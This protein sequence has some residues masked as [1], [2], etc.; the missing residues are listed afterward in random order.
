VVS[1]SEALLTKLG[2]RG[3]V[4]LVWSD[5]ELS[6]RELIVE[7]DRWSERLGAAGLRAGSVLGLRGD[8]SPATCAVTLA[9]LQLRLVLVP[10]TRSAESEGLASLGRVEVL[11]DVAPDDTFSIGPRRRVEANDVLD[12][13]RE[14]GR[15]GLIV[16]SSGST[17]QPKAILHDM[18][19]VL[20]KFEHRRRGYRTLQFLLMDHFGGINTLLSVLSYGGV[21]VAPQDRTPGPVARLI[22]RRGIEL[23]PVTPTFLNLFLASGVATRHDLASVEV[24]TYGTEVMPEATLERLHRAFPSARLQQTYGLSE[25]GVLRSRSKDSDSLWMKVGGEGFETRIEDGTLRVRSDYAMVGYLNAPSPIDD[26]GWMDTGDAVVQEGDW[27]RILGRSSDIINVGGQK[28]FPA[29]VEDTLLEAPRV[30]DAVVR[31]ESHPLMGHVVVAHVSLAEPEDDQVLRERLRAFCRQRLA[32]FK[33]PVRF[34]SDLSPR[35]TERFKK[36]R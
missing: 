11:V 6:G 33:V 16:F 9:A 28:V 22:E 7:S 25:I 21:V 1:R 32:P 4:T 20:A 35:H 36:A 29:E 30:L 8:Y 23:L 5:R 27:L 2:E 3:A 26:D 17:G 31:G 24:I 10:L 12:P 18:E 19:R 13:F 15:P 34:T 14:A